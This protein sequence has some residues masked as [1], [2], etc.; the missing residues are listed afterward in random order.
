[1]FEDEYTEDLYFFLMKYYIF[2][3]KPVNGVLTN[4][5]KSLRF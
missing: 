5:A 3:D 4:S 2:V 1:M